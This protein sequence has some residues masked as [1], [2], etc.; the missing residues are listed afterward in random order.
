MKKRKKNLSAVDEK[1]QNDIVFFVE[2]RK[3]TTMTMEA[4]SM[5]A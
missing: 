1:K 5:R 2:P 3:N 4:T